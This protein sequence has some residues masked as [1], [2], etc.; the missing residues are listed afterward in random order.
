MRTWRVLL[1]P[2]AA[3]DLDKLG[4]R[5][6]DRVRRFFREKLTTRQDPRRLGHA[7]KGPYAGF[8]TFRVGDLR[9]I[10]D[11]QDD[12]VRILVVRVG[13]RRDVYR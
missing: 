2:K 1:D 4:H 11:I 5:E 8:W 6:Q 7:L 12:Q 10:S 13:N 9:I 3:K